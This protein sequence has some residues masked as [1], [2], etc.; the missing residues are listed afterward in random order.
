MSEPVVGCSGKCGEYREIGQMVL[1]VPPNDYYCWNCVMNT[2]NLRE[3]Y[4]ELSG[5]NHDTRD[6]FTDPEL[7]YA[8]R[9]KMTDKENKQLND[10]W[11]RSYWRTK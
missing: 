1:H 11:V 4:N 10:S 8:Q 2:T 6:V 9:R 7:N 3:K 5:E